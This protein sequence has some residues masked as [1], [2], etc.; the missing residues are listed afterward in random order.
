MVGEFPRWI[1]KTMSKEGKNHRLVIVIDGLD[2]LDHR[3]NAMNLV[4]LPIA[5]P[6]NVKLIFSCSP[7]ECYNSLQRREYPLI[8]LE[9]L[10]EGER[11]AFIRGYLNKV[12]K[13]L[14]E[15]QV[16]PLQS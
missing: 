9:P 6:K 16:I 10:E 1:E 11:K 8:K 7:G 12:S 3:D 4:W 13:K 14:T 5:F 15:A 2:A